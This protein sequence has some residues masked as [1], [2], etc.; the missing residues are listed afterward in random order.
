M[1]LGAPALPTDNDVSSVASDLQPE[2]VL[3]RFLMGLMCAAAAGTLASAQPA[4]SA[5]P[6]FETR[7]VAEGV[8]AFRYG[9]YQALFV[10][11]TAGVIVTDPSS[12]G[13][14]DVAPTYLAEIRKVTSAPIR[15]L[16][17]T[18][19]GYD[20]IAGGQLFKDQGATVVA[21]RNTKVQLERMNK[22]PDVVPVD[23][24]IGDGVTP[25]KLGATTVN[26]VYPGPTRSDNM[27]SLWLPK[28]KVLFAADWISVGS[29]PCM[30]TSCMPATWN[31]DKALQT[32]IALDWTQFVPGHP[33]P[34]GRFGTKADLEQ[35]RTYLKDLDAFTGALARERKCN[36]DS[37]RTA[38]VP[39]KYQDFVQTQVYRDHVE[40]YCLTWNQ[41]A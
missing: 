3:K 19:S 21:H 41:G 18:H 25:L 14:P 4:P 22:A 12:R 13:N 9:G 29:A 8:Y 40:R 24:V 32:V 2:A 34:G 23:R 37:W 31:Y 17:Y 16:V 1:E 7:K 10:V 11:T 35:I 39:A 15:Y 5:A 20:H 38:E 27:L 28:E 30:N 6:S 26:L 33:G 36:A